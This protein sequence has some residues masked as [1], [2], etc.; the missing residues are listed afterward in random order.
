M[1]GSR[2]GGSGRGRWL[3]RARL[4][5]RRRHSTWCRQGIGSGRRGGCRG[6]CRARGGARRGFGSRRF[7]RRCGRRVRL[8]R[9]VERRDQRRLAGILG[10][11]RAGRQRDR[12]LLGSRAR[13]GHRRVV[14]GSRRGSWGGVDRNGAL[15]LR[16]ELLGLAACCRR[17]V[18]RDGGDV[19]LGMR[20]VR[21]RLATPVLAVNDHGHQAQERARYQQS[22]LRLARHDSPSSVGNGRGPPSP[23]SAGRGHPARGPQLRA[24][25]PRVVA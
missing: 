6:W 11:G 8:C 4:G 22:N 12:R 16:V 2:N 10:L 23:P 14:T 17:R 19:R 7:G 15:D 3:G 20:I 24:A 21:R 13:C 25:S 18:S 9:I 5:R 1:I